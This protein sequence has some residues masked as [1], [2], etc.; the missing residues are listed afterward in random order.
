[1]FLSLNVHPGQEVLALRIV[2]I[3]IHCGDGMGLHFLATI[4]MKRATAGYL[5]FPSLRYLILSEASPQGEGGG[6]HLPAVCPQQP[7][8]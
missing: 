3:S 1:M 5:P 6:S 4:Y 7:T 2:L 8:A